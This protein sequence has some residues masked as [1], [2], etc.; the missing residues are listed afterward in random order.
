MKEIGE[1]IKD[2]DYCLDT[3]SAFSGIW[4][5]IRGGLIAVNDNRNLLAKFAAWTHFSKSNLTNKR[6][7]I[8]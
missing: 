8:F 3:G 6:N 7:R 2:K 5:M 1:G 4:E